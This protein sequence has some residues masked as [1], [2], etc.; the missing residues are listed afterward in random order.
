MANW[1]AIRC[2][3][4]EEN[5]IERNRVLSKADH[6]EILANAQVCVP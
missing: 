4:E 2:L 3:D 5:W 1:E 6:V